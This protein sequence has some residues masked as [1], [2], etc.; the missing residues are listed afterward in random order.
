MMRLLLLVAPCGS[1]AAQ[2]KVKKPLVCGAVHVA[3]ALLLD[4]SLP[5]V[6]AHEYESAPPS[7][8][9]ALQPSEIAPPGLA[10]CALTVTASIT[11]GKLA[12]NTVMVKSCDWVFDAPSFTLT[13]N[14]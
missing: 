2:V 14:T 13:V 6:A 3:L 8:S 11:G 4:E 1:E 10:D 7:G 5:P 9:W 12:G